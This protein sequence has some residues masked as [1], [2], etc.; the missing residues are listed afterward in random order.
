MREDW[1]SWSAAL[2]TFGLAVSLL[3]I[4]IN[5]L[6]LLSRDLETQ[7]FDPE[8]WVTVLGFCCASLVVTLVVVHS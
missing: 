7:R 4:L 1:G 8:L 6:P 2:V 5:V 3:P